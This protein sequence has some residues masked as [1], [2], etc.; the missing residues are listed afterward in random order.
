[1]H[2]PTIRERAATLRKE[3]YS[4]NYI[5]KLTSV[6][7]ATLSDWL[8]KHP[9]TPNKY[10][11]EYIGKARAAAGA[12]KNQIK[13]ESIENARI[14]ASHDIDTLSKRDLFMLGLGIYIGEG[15]KSHGITKITNA[16]PEIIR[17]SIKWFKEICGAKM[18]NFKIRLHLYPDNNV[19]KSLDFWSQQTGI[20]IS[21]FYS[22]V[23]DR[24]ENKKMAKRGKLLNGTAHL[25]VCKLNND[26][27]GVKLHRLILSWI[28]RVLC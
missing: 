20:P 14:K 27:L 7:K 19:D 21:Q 1:M 26:A 16:S 25:L 5:S 8:S 6:P 18:E 9:Y 12:R 11:I 10:T 22:S 17:I 23:T 3:G 15:S 4:Y 24:R 13:R 28:E 2:R